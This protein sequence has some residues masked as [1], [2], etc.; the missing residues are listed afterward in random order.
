VGSNDGKIYA[1]KL[2]DG[3]LSWNYEM[4]KPIKSSPTIDSAD[5][6]LFIGAD[7]GK[8][9]CVDT[10]NGTEKWVVE[11]LGAVKSTA[12]L[13]DN[14]IVFGSDDGTVYIL[15]KYTGKEEW[16]YNPGYY[17]MNAPF[18]SS[19]V[20]YG[21]MIYIGG[22]DGYLYALKNDKESG[23]ISIFAYYIGGAI[24]VILAL[25]VGLRAIRGRKKKEE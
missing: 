13:L 8:V 2:E 15:N 3:A 24:V 17:L 10:R 18:E 16:T 7:N 9:A 25:L 6:S 11:G 4:G 23:P 1:L 5:N 21:N 14:K 22:N 12:A 19:P 20:V